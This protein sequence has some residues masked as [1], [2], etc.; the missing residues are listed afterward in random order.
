MFFIKEVGWLVRSG[1]RS[2]Q[3]KGLGLPKVRNPRLRLILSMIVLTV[4]GLTHLVLIHVLDARVFYLDAGRLLSGTLDLVDL[5][6]WSWTGSPFYGEWRLGSGANL[7]AAAPLLVT[8]NLF[9]QYYF[10]TLMLALAVPVYFLACRA[11]RWDGLFKWVA[12]IIFAQGLLLLFT[13]LAPVNTHF[14]PLVLAVIFYLLV[15]GSQRKAWARFLIWPAIGLAMHLH[16]A[17]GLLMLPAWFVGEPWRRRGAPWFAAGFGLLVL[18]QSPVLRQLW[19][20]DTAVWLHGPGGV[21]GSEMI[22]AYGRALLKWL[23]LGPFLFGLGGAFYLLP[24]LAF[25]RRLVAANPHL[26][27]LLR[28]GV[29]FFAAAMLIFPLLVA[30]KGVMQ[31]D[32]LYPGVILAGLLGGLFAQNLQETVTPASRAVR[33]RH[34]AVFLA[35]VLITEAFALAKGMTYPPEYFGMM[36]LRD[37]TEIADRLAALIARRDI[38]SIQT[39]TTVY[40]ADAGAPQ[41]RASSPFTF[42]TL[43]LY[44]HPDLRDHFSQTPERIINIYLAPLKDRPGRLETLRPADQSVIDRFET[45]HLSVLITQAEDA[46]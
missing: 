41:P 25:S 17:T 36:R 26:Q 10:L 13:P 34:V 27:S 46:R 19:I 43:L 32:Y 2:N 30:I 24:G 4:I 37:Q 5:G 15:K 23:L 21:G 22:G 14:L 12:T 35:L 45:E 44:R 7:L 33:R 28:G 40:D 18:L 6:E 11:L 29:W 39:R 31:Y 9:A 3:C 20:S 42:N 38:Q 1:R 16:L 8:R